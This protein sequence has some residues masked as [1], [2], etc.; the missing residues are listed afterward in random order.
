MHIVT[1]VVPRLGNSVVVY[2]W[3]KMLVPV[4]LLSIT[5]QHNLVS[6]HDGSVNDNNTDVHTF[7]YKF[8][9]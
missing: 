8:K 4:V 1:S 5:V 2:C 3:I 6:E 9:N 7:I